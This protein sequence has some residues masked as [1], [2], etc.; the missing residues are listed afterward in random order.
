M[1]WRS[2]WTTLANYQPLATWDKQRARDLGLN[3]V[4]GG[5]LRNLDEHLTKWVA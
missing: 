3:V 4:E 2:G 5:Q 1:T